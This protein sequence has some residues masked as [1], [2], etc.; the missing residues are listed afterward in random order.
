MR[1][2]GGLSYAPQIQYKEDVVALPTGEQKLFDD[3]TGVVSKAVSL[4]TGKQKIDASALEEMIGAVIG[5]CR[6][7][8]VHS[9][10]DA[11]RSGADVN[12]AREELDAGDAKVAARQYETAVR[13]YRAAWNHS[14]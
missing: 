5:A 10:E 8:S 14:H 1:G 13:H 7:V 6:V 3:A 9:I 11:A 4:L 2:R 12:S